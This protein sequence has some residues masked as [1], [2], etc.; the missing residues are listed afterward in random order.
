MVHPPAPPTIV[1]VGEAQIQKKL[2]VA[3]LQ[4]RQLSVHRG[5]GGR[6]WRQSPF[7]PRLGVLIQVLELQLGHHFCC[8]ASLLGTMVVGW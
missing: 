5:L 6:R 2:L 8:V 3:G 1:P 7:A 4:Q